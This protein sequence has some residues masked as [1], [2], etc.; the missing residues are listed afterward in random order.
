MMLALTSAIGPM[1]KLDTLLS[2]HV[3][4]C[5]QRKSQLRKMPWKEKCGCQDVEVNGVEWNSEEEK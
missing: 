1:L 4:R 5:L 3:C 2:R